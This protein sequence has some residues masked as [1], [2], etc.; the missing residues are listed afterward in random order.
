MGRKDLLKTII[1]DNQARELPILWS[2]EQKIPIA[3]NKIITIAGVRRSGKTYHAFNIMKQLTD[4]GVPSTK[5]LY[6][7]F[8][9]ERLKLEK[10]ELDLILQAFRELYPNQNLQECYF[11]FDELQEVNGW[12]KFINRMYSTITKNIFI[13]GSNAKLLSQEIATSLRG[14]TITYQVYPLSFKEFVTITNPNPLNVY[15]SQD[16]AKLVALFNQFLYQGGFPEII[17]K[18]KELQE[19]ILQEYFNVMLIK[20]LIERYKISQVSVIKHFCKR[21]VAGS[22]GEFSVN[23]I[24][25]E[26]KSQGYKISK[27][28]MYDYQDYVDNIYLARFIPKYAHSVVKSA[29]SQKKSYVIDQGF[30]IA[31]DFKFAQDTGRLLETVIALELIKAGKQ[32]AY[33]S[34]GSECDFVVIEKDQVT[35]AIQVTQELMDEETRNREIKG[36]VTTCKKFGLSTGVIVTMDT[37]EEF[38]IDGVEVKIM[39]AWK[40]LFSIGV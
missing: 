1:T 2:R 27:D 7:N 25:N 16:T 35:Q 9:D 22:G 20:D 11:F 39:P 40:Y 36:L 23:K 17:D 32:I 10:G 26:L 18:G 19:K 6:L 21:V 3:T 4:Q 38:V 33:D 5:M 12:E 29:M 34:N 15:N 13:T 14:R 30:G 28:S 31:L 24:Y 8:E 37:D